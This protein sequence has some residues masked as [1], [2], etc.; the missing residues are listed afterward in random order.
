MNLKPADRHEGTN[1][2]VD[3]LSNPEVNRSSHDRKIPISS[4]TSSFV[5][6]SLSELP[7]TSNQTEELAQPPQRDESDDCLSS[8]VVINMDEMKE[9]EKETE[10]MEN[11]ETQGNVKLETSPQQMPQCA[12]PVL[13][14]HASHPTSKQASPVVSQHDSPVASK[15][16]SPVA[17]QHASEGSSKRASPV[18]S[19]HSSHPTSKLASPVV[20]QHGSPVASKNVTP[21]A[22]QH[23]SQGSSKHASPLSSQPGSP[24]ASQ[25]ASQKSSEY[26]SPV[27]SH[28]S[29]EQTFKAP[30]SATEAE[31]GIAVE[32]PNQVADS[33][34]RKESKLSSIF[35]FFKRG[36]VTRSR[37]EVVSP[38]ARDVNVAKRSASEGVKISHAHSLSRADVQSGP[39]VD[40][41]AASKTLSETDP[42]HLQSTTDKPPSDHPERVIPT[43]HNQGETGPP[44]KETS[45]A[46]GS[47]TK[48][49]HLTVEPLHPASTPPPAKLPPAVGSPPHL[50]KN[51]VSLAS[52]PG[53][54]VEL[55]PT[56]L[57]ANNS[58]PPTLDVQF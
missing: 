21:V 56:S 27:V 19:R 11:F 34:S 5:Y 36:S 52:I 57:K 47:L 3:S 9:K 24:V 17:S 31:D 32:P 49:P 42:R 58:S 18:A 45:S 44:G 50:V 8:F 35:S 25:H 6:I 7:A 55:L 23:A 1:N 26:S 40:K 15:N 37:S 20:S 33:Q 13:S 41:D 30:A 38:S 28:R 14:Q 39:V 10:S 54:L 29:S 22:S 12:S 4:K 53:N 43:E 51:P 2:K 46:G 16:A 48:T